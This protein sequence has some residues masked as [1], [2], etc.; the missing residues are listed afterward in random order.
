MDSSL[1]K[2][3]QSLTGALLY[4]AVNTRPDVAYSVGMLCRAMGKPTV[5][6][7]DAA[8]RVLYYL[9]H[10]GQVGLHYSASELDLSGMSDADWAVHYS[11]S[12][13]VFTYNQ[14][15]ISWG[16]KKQTCVALSSVIM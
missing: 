10:H 13:F 7:L 6:L 16:S 8:Y 4:C 9:Y 2:A 11:T 12:G 15:A 5:P 1:L 3:Y 14:A